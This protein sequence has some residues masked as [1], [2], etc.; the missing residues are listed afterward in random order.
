MRSIWP[1]FFWLGWGLWIA[2]ADLRAGGVQPAV[3]KL[4]VGGAVL[5]FGRPRTWWI[6]S[7]A[8]GAWVPLEP[9]IASVF[10]MTHTLQTS[11]LGLLLPP[12]PALLGGLVGRALARKTT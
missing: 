2:I 4:L 11:P 3:I 1:F 12:I 9:I 10:H 8:L 7:L 5:G 6:W